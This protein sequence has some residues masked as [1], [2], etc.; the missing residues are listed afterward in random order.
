MNIIKDSMTAKERVKT[1]FDGGEVDRLPCF[2]F[3]GDMGCHF[4]NVDV[5]KYYTDAETMKDVEVF[6][7]DKF[8]M[9]NMGV[10][11][12]GKLIAE[13]YGG[14]VILPKD[15]VAYIKKSPLED[16]RDLDNYKL[17]NPY[18][19]GRLPTV[20]KSLDMLIKE[21]GHRI[22][23]GTAT[24]GPMTIAASLRDANQLMRD[25]R[26]DPENVHK[27]LE[28]SLQTNIEY[29]K[30]VYNEFGVGVGIA[31]PVSSCTLIGAKY[32][33]EFS[34]P[35]LSRLCDEIL[36]ITGS[37]PSL[38]ICGSTKSIWKDLSEINISSFS[39]DNCEDIGELK[40]AIGDSKCIV[41]NVKPVETLKFGTYEDVL[42]ESRICIEKGIDSKNGYILSS[43]CQIPIG[44]CE[45]NVHGLVDGCRLYARGVKMNKN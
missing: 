42:E 2:V 43:G 20:M 3:L 27:L 34:K 23:V 13:I 36:K 6:L 30:A 44:T 7:L 38:H 33:R 25:M 31:D 26:K 32:F 35:Y 29:V 37:K 45:E 40:D 39:L 8:S 41:G 24:V 17:M 28:F 14:Q 22:D 19:D 1:Y 4:M 11:I 10:G 16:Y 21:V 15:E 18:K 9:D 12:D 5:S